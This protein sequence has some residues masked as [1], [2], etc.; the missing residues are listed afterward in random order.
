MMKIKFKIDRKRTLIFTL[1]IQLATLGIIGLDKLGIDLFLLRQLIL[2]IYLTFVP[3]ILVISILK[4]LNKLSITEIVL[5]SVGLSN[6]FLMIVGLI[7]NSIYPIFGISKPISELPLI[8]TIGVCNLVLWG[9]YFIRGELFT[10][11][12]EINLRKSYLL[13]ILLPIL[14][15]F[16]TYFLTYYNSNVILLFMF[17]ILSIVPIL[18][19]L[20]F[21]EDFYPAILWVISISLLFQ[22]SLVSTVVPNGGDAT[23]EYHCSKL[24]LNY[25]I[26]D[27]TGSSLSSS[28]VYNLNSMLRIVIL[29]PIFS[30]LLE[31][32]LIWEFKIVHPLIFSLTPV[33]LYLIY[34]RQTNSK[35]GFLSSCLF[36]F[37]FPFFTTLAMNTRTGLAILFLMF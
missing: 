5:Y 1:V 11:W 27:P 32:S 10:K 25:G 23:C 33:A 29:H 34:K 14:S 7:I 30:I 2:F 13:I 3:G 31:M 17:A 26:W 12:F 37:I 36:M 21:P 22:T 16:G 6:S 18:A 9:L 24:V 19:I 28:N 8:V 20:K 15:I 35:I 4:L